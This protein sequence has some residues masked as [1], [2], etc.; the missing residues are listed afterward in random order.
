M[1]PAVLTPGRKLRLFQ[2]SD[3]FKQWWSLDELRF[4]AKCEHLFIGREIKVLEDDEG[5][6][7]FRCPTLKCESTWE[8][9]QYPELHL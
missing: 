3:P 5:A 9:W 2:Q 8:D 7:H 1:S 4:C 6:L